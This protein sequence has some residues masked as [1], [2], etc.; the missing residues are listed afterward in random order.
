MNIYK[1]LRKVEAQIELWINELD[2]Y[3]LETIKIKPSDE[4]WSVGQVY[5]HLIKSSSLFHLKQVEKCL[6]HN[7]N[8]SE[9]MNIKG[10]V[11]FHLLKGFPPIKIKVPPSPE[12]TPAQPTNIPNLKNEL[13]ELKA[14]LTNHIPLLEQNSNKGKEAHPGF[15]YMNANE[16]FRLIPM[17]FEHHLRQKSRIDKFIKICQQQN[18]G[19]L[20]FQKTM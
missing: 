10:L 11:S 13:L 19:S 8:K 6:S 4:E 3:N 14:T 18:T 5:V 1:S 12:Y 15:S 16:W 20:Q 9:K 7:Q 17:H 2:K